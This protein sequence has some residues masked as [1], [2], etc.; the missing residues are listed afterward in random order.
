MICY[1]FFKYINIFIKDTNHRCDRSPST[2]N[3][4]NESFKLILWVIIFSRSFDVRLF[5]NFSIAFHQHGFWV[6]LGIK[7]L[8]LY[9]IWI[10]MSYE[11]FKVELWLHYN[12]NST[13]KDGFSPAW[14]YTNGS[15]TNCCNLQENPWIMNHQ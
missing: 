2:N 15:K 8:V 10:C 9:W 5:Y 3:H 13:V 6:L 4:R 11:C 14:T 12:E 7:L 1:V